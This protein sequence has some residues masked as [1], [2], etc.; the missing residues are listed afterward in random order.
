V[1]LEGEVERQPVGRSIEVGIQQ[2]ES[3]D[4]VNRERARRRRRVEW[5]AGAIIERLL[6]L[7]GEVAPVFPVVG[8][9]RADLIVDERESGGPVDRGEELREPG[10]H[11]SNRAC[12]RAILAMNSAV[13]IGT[14]HLPSNDEPG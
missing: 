11:G 8:E 12:R 2:L 13:S 10:T 7:V 9:Q 1:Q 5:L 3:L 14:L 6:E 4:H